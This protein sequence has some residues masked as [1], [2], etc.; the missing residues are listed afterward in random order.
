MNFFSRTGFALPDDEDSAALGDEI[1]Y[2]DVKL[3]IV[4]Q[5]G[6]DEHDFNLFDDRAS[7]LWRK[8]YI[9]GAVQE[10]TSGDTRSKD[11]L[12][13]SVEK[14]MMA[15][16]DR[17]PDVRTV[18]QSSQVSSANVQVDVTIENEDDMLNDI[19]RHPELYSD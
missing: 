19:R 1:D 7:L 16:G 13:E 17:N 11:Q 18:G 15:A 5:E 4:Q 14:M 9:D 10:L 2:Q 3:K 8:P 12:R 6:Y